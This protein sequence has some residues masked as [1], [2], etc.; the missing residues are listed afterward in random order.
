L[1]G[2]T[3]G[4]KGGPVTAANTFDGYIGM[5]LGKTLQKIYLPYESFPQT[6]GT[7]MTQLAALGC[8][9]LINVEPSQSMTSTEQTVLAK[10]LARM[11]KTGI[12]YR[13]VLYSESNNKNF[14]TV[15]AWQ[16]YWSY[17]A[18]VIKDAGV[19]CA[20]DAGCSGKAFGR[21][22]AYFPA[23]PAPDELWLDYYATSFR[24]GA[25]LEPLIAMAQSAGISSGIGEWGWTSGAVVFTP[26]TMPWWNEYCAYMV[27]LANA[28][29]LQV[30]SIYFDAIA[31]G[32]SGNF[33]GTPDDLRIPGIR[34]VSQAIAAG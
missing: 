8:Q 2:A 19:S 24:G 9:F 15:Q 18:P 16:A 11:N 6:P 5:P 30:G 10:W 25:R 23:N 7:K 34:S 29:D 17:Y 33:I 4:G 28:G 12:K 20:Y 32:R 26:M 14:P 21:A 3:V 31:F 22:Q 27:H 13:V 1:A